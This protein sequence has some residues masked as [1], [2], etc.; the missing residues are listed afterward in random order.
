MTLDEAFEATITKAEAISEI[1]KHGHAPAEF[2][3]DVGERAEYT[4]QD[5]LGWLGY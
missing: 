4:G 5:V 3:A 2:F 1:E